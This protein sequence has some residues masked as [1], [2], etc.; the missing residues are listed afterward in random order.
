MTRQ[1]PGGFFT[2]KSMVYSFK[3]PENV[4]SKVYNIFLIFQSSWSMF[5]NDSFHYPFCINARIISFLVRMNSSS[6]SL[7][8][9]ELLEES[10]AYNI[11]STKLFNPKENKFFTQRK[12]SIDRSSWSEW[13]FGKPIKIFIEEIFKFLMVAML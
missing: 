11:L 10:Y 12:L 1:Y 13:K 9:I 3:W 5:I 7:N 8:K 6:G 2:E 4:L